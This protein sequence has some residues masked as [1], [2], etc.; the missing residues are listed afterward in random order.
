MLGYRECS[1]VLVLEV[2]AFLAGPVQFLGLEALQVV[3]VPAV[4]GGILE[5]ATREGTHIL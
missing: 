5:R 4:G 2:L 3:S 1:L